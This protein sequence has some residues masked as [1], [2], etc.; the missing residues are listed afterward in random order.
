MDI[1]PLTVEDAD[2]TADL[3]DRF[4]RF[5]KTP[6]VVPAEEIREELNDPNINPDADTRGYW[7]D[8][9]LVAYGLIWHRP[10]GE[11]QERAYTQGVVDPAFRGQGVGRHLLKW[12]IE[13]ARELLAS[14]NND[15]PKYIRAD[16]WDWIEDAQHLYQRLDMTPVRYFKDMIRLLDSPATIDEIDGIQIVPFDR[17]LDEGALAVWNESFADHWGSTPQ[18][19]TS[20]AHRM[21]MEGTKP[22]LSFL[23]MNGD[24]VV[25]LT[26]NGRYPEDDEVIGRSEGWIEVLGVKE[27]W[28]GKGVAK[29]LL[30]S[31]FNAFS[32]AGFTHAAL[33]VDSENPTGAFGLYQGL[34]FEPTTGTITSEIEL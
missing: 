13:R 3:L 33:G 9:T 10:S 6:L 8:G 1:R 5:W 20:Y 27:A 12:E 2:E 11:R 19:A 21:E 32:A 24:E 30:K 18:D 34:G 29:S 15:L 26:L 25:G 31:S 4:N 22:E 28:R 17:S 14:I 16:E 7:L 23:A